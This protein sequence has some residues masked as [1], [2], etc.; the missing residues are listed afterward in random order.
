MA[1]RSCSSGRRG[2]RWPHHCVGD[3]SS[4]RKEKVVVTAAV[5]HTITGWT[6]SLFT[7]RGTDQL[8]MYRDTAQQPLK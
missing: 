6:P 7:T 2:K 1:T 3:A 8:H 4:R 5:K